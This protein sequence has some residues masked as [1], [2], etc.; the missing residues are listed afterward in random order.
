[1]L[2]AGI[3][4]LGIHGLFFSL[5]FDWNAIPSLENPAPLVLN[6]TLS[7][8]T[9]KPTA[10]PAP[11]K[12]EPVLE[13]QTMAQNKIVPVTKKQTRVKK[14]K[15]QSKHIK[16]RHIKNTSLPKPVQI[17]VQLKTD[18][19]SKAIAEKTDGTT[20][21]DSGN[22]KNES[23]P[24]SI[25]VD[26]DGASLSPLQTIHEAR[27]AYR[28]NPS[29]KYPRI[30]RIRGYQGNVLLDV[31]VNENGKVDEVNIFRSS[32]Y[33]VL[34]RAATSTVKQWLFEPGSIGE[35][36]V[37]MWVRVPIRFELTE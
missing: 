24:A 33:P 11:Q 3:L 13:K 37:G 17:P 16:H 21:F 18:N 4:A 19:T 20:T 7:S 25:P 15:L 30:A 9:G 2:T 8:A 5:D 28:S 26:Q 1:M 12:A 35:K 23:K 27:P 34:D 31:F 32:G 14:S 6:L 36:K 22:K 10:N 29:P